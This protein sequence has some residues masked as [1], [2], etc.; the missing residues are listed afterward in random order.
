M[1]QNVKNWIV[2]KFIDSYVDGVAKSWREKLRTQPE[3]VQTLVDKLFNDPVMGMQKWG[4]EK[5]YNGS[6]DNVTAV[7][8]ID[9]ALDPL[10]DDVETKV[11]GLIKKFNPRNV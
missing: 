3:D 8:V 9:R 2:S 5:L 1:L 10:R 11:M 7:D 4:L 6:L